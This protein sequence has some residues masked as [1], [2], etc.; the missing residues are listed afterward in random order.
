MTFTINSNTFPAPA[1]WSESY[2]TIEN[3]NQSEAGTDLVDLVRAHK[4]TVSIQTNVTQAQKEVLLTL[5]A[6]ATVSVSVNGGTAKTMRMRGFS[7]DRVRFSN[8]NTSEL[9]QCSY[10]LTEV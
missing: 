4:L 8:K 3:V 5:S 7:A 1:S 9:W 10:T 6:L 2:D